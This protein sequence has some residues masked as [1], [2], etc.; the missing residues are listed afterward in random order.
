[1][2][3]RLS[4]GIVLLFLLA[5]LAW[6]AS[7]FHQAR[8]TESALD[9][10]LLSLVFLAT[11]GWLGWV[12]RQAWV[13]PR[14][15]ERAEALWASDHPVQ[16]I[17]SLVASTR[18]ARSETGYRLRLL[19][20]WAQ[21]AAGRSSEARRESLEAHLVRLPL[22]MRLLT[23]LHFRFSNHLPPQRA[24]VWEDRLHRLAPRLAPLMHHRAIRRLR[25]D[26]PHWE[27]HGWECFLEA[28]PASQDD[29]LLLESMMLAA[30]DRLQPV[31]DQAPQLGHQEWSPVVPYL[32]EEAL[33]LL[34]QRHGS[35]RIPWD[36]CRPALYLLLQGR[37]LEVVHLARSLPL[38]L[39]PVLL[40]EAEIAALR[41]SGCLQEAH[42][43][44]RTALEIHPSSFRLWMEQFHLAMAI[45]NTQGGLESLEMAQRLLSPVLEDPQRRE[46]LLRRAEFAHWVERDSNR[47]W[48]MLESLPESAR[49]E[50]LL[51]VLQVQ[52]VLARFEEALEGSRRLLARHP[53]NPDALMVH[54]ECLAGMQAWE[55]LAPLLEKAPTAALGRAS[56][57]HLKG[58]SLVHR[59]DPHGAREC[60]ERAAQMEPNEPRFVLDAA[61]AC[62]DLGEFL[63][64]EQQGRHALLLDSRCEE[65]FVLLAQARQAQL[66][67]DGARRFLRECL[68][69]HPESEEAQAFLAE[70]EAH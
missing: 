45:G 24:R 20:S 62:L 26:S 36:R 68:L 6:V 34:S 42:F 28:L 7:L 55:A 21:W 51:L 18:L 61:H 59:Q 10:A 37:P 1:M 56:F 67:L 41:Q 69:H 44:V 48:A 3:W 40:C 32:F 63:R 49:E 31:Q 2:P 38:V 53:E 52:V 13:F 15:L 9:S 22:V 23:R 46:W 66:D 65:A 17:L 25:E 39:R 35:G 27:Q 30:L 4:R 33:G 47:A 12:I 14:I 54:A 60:L 64:A 5:A 19:A 50:N 8:I 16:E 43:A 58:L 29:P 70:L 57:W 11:T